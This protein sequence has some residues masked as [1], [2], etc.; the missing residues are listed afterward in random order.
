MNTP[1]QAPPEPRSLASLGE[2][3]KLP[4]SFVVTEI[5]ETINEING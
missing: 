2:R 1:Y 3:R 4:T 5:I